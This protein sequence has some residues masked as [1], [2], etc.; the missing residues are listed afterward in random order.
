MQMIFEDSANSVLSRFLCRAYNC[1]DANNCNE[2]YFCGGNTEIISKVRE[3]CKENE[4]YILFVDVVPDNFRTIALYRKVVKYCQ[5][6]SNIFVIPI[7][8]IEYY[9]IKT[10]G[11]L[12]N[13]NVA[14][15]FIGHH[16]KDTELTRIQLRGVY[17]S[18]EK[19]CKM[20]VEHCLLPCQKS[21]GR[22]Y[23]ED[24]L[25]NHKLYNHSCVQVG[26]KEKAMSLVLKLPVHISFNSEQDLG[27]KVSMV[28][29]IN[30]KEECTQLYY[31][32]A[33]DF[34]SNGYI[35]NINKL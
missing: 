13:N 12:N 5:E 32:I 22:F 30:I 1:L 28:D 14:E 35:Y 25:C 17:K 34:K 33:N 27:A 7:P 29:L 10:W 2:L 19:Y 8:C 6:K 20:V 26:V 18:F 24:C 4:S 16:V 21:K 15:V 9:V 23:Q 31:N 11:D 3:H